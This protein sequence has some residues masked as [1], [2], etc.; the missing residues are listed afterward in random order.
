M[1]KLKVIL[2]GVVLGVVVG[3]WFGVNIG[4]NKP[5]YSNPFAESS[6]RD[7]LRDASGRLIEKGGRA[8]EKGGEAIR[9]TDQ[10]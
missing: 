3:L 10:K 1:K 9:G 8:I 7:L 5:V 2:L 6:T 4:K